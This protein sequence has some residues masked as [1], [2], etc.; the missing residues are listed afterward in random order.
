MDSEGSGKKNDNSGKKEESIQD[1]DRDINYEAL[2]IKS[3][4]IDRE[5]QILGVD[6][7]GDDIS[8]YRIIRADGSSKHY[9]VFSAMLDDFDR[10]DLL[11]LHRL[12]MKKFESNAPEG[13]DLLL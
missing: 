7:Q 5:S 8:Y 11:D 10:Q 6:L 9:K 13:Y 3:L 1:E 4:I 12:V 2:A